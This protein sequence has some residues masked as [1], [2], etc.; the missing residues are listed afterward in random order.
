MIMLI[1]KVPAG[2]VVW[3]YQQV[4]HM[5]GFILQQMGCISC[6]K[7]NDSKLI[8]LVIWAKFFQHRQLE[9]DIH[10]II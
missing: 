5:L 8:T 1:E 2:P 9:V 10:D 7:L 4:Q 3:Y 6:Y